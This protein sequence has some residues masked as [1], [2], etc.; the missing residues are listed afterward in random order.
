[1]K[2]KLLI[3]SAVIS[4]ISWSIG[5]F[6]LSLDQLQSTESIRVLDSKHIIR[7]QLIIQQEW[8]PFREQTQVTEAAERGKQI[9]MRQHQHL[10]EHVIEQP[11]NPSHEQ[12]TKGEIWM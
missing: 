5:L 3:P 6:V 11:V 8:Q 12:F 9:R 1:M 7:N 10:K 2:K 4:V